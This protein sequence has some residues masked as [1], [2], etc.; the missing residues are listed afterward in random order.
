MTHQEILR[1][2]QEE[3]ELL[4]GDIGEKFGASSPKK[5]SRRSK[6]MRKE[7]NGSL[8]TK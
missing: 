3:E 8:S 2:I 6:A 7:E 5:L 4:Q 1:E